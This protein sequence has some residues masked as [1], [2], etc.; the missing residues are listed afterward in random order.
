MKRIISLLLV[1][2]FM[3]SAS[4]TVNALPVFDG[5][6]QLLSKKFDTFLKRHNKKTKAKKLS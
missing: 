3:L 2:V 4:V 1:A 5:E 6:V